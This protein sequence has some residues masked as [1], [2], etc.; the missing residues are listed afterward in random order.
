MTGLIV[1]STYSSIDDASK[2]VKG[3]IE[4]RLAACANLIPIRSIY[5]WKGKIEDNGEILVIY[6][7]TVA[8][9]KSL[10]AYIEETHSYDVPEVMDIAM[11]GVSKKYLNWRSDST[12]QG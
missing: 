1:I 9:A 8:K 7:T 2:I 4:R 12:S 10:H 5:S 6:K 11:D 3:A